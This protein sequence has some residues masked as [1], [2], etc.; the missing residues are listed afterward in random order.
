MKR[1]TILGYLTTGSII[2]VAGCTG[3]SGPQCT[4]AKLDEPGDSVR[5]EGF[6]KGA[7]E[8]DEIEIDVWSLVDYPVVAEVSVFLYGERGN[9]IDVDIQSITLQGMESVSYVVDGFFAA[10]W[11]LDLDARCP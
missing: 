6:A 3:D 1:R 7:F 4:Q 10:D 5:V 11:N 9:I 8:I 2:G